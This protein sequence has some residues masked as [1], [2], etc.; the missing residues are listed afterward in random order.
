MSYPKVVDRFTLDKC[1][2]YFCA[3][4]REFVVPEEGEEFL[5]CPFCTLEVTDYGSFIDAVCD[6]ELD[7]E[8][9]GDS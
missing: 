8:L 9:H 2:V 7:S 4:C 3:S 5:E 1:D 6:R